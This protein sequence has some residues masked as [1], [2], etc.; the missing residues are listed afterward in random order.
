MLRGGK[1]TWEA[2]G[3]PVADQLHPHSLDPLGP[4]NPIHTTAEWKSYF[5]RYVAWGDT[6]VDLI[7]ADGTLALGRGE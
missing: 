7:R 6:I 5:D 1:K 4:P 3:L 2:A